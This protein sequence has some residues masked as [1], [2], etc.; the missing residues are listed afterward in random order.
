MFVG[1]FRQFVLKLSQRPPQNL[2]CSR[3]GIQYLLSAVGDT[4]LTQQSSQD[5]SRLNV[6]VRQ[7]PA[8]ELVFLLVYDKIP[9]KKIKYYQCFRGLLRRRPWAPSFILAT[10]RIVADAPTMRSDG[11]DLVRSSGNK[12]AKAPQK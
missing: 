12:T 11:C 4:A 2:Q 3:E 1:I 5:W 7:H 9:S 6:N 8:K 10:S